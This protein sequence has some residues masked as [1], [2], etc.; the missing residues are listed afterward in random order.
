MLWGVIIG[1]SCVLMQIDNSDDIIWMHLAYNIQLKKVPGKFYFSTFVCVSNM[2]ICFSIFPGRHSWYLMKRLRRND[3]QQ[4]GYHNQWIRKTF[5]WTKK[6]FTRIGMRVCVISSIKNKE[7]VVIAT[8]LENPLSNVLS[9][10]LTLLQAVDEI[11]NILHGL[12]SS[13]FPK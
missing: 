11:C 10:F 5:N 8:Q 9:S 12:Y 13:T 4:M 3:T 2:T 7:K 6:F 1:K